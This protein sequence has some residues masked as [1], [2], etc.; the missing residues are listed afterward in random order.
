MKSIIKSG[1]AHRAIVHKHQSEM[2]IPTTWDHIKDAIII[3]F[4]VTTIFGGVFLGVYYT[5]H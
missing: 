4:G 2:L 1:F 5:I 3:L